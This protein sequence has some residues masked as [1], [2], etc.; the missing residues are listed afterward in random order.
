MTHFNYPLF[1]FIMP[2]REP[3]NPAVANPAMEMEMLSKEML[4]KN[5]KSIIRINNTDELCCARALVTAKTRLDQHPKYHSIRQ[6]GKLQRELALRLH[7]EARVPPGPCIYDA[8][9]AFSAAP[10]LTGYQIIL[11]DAN[12]SFHITTF[13][14]TQDKQLILLHHQ[15]HYDVITRLPGF[16]GA[17][18]VCAYCWK[19]YNTRDVIDATRKSNAGPVA[20]KSAPISW[21]RTPEV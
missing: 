13:G 15:G 1:K 16:S 18:Y 10:S 12:R 11:V 6:G 21:R 17:S 19:P 3:A 8:L 7:D 14:G 9:T 20:K 2:L 4:T 5:S